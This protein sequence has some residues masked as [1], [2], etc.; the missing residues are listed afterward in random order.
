MDLTVKTS[1]LQ[2]MVSKV[3]KCVSNNKLIPITSLMS[4]KV[5]DNVLTLTTTDASAYFYVSSKERFLCDDFEISVIADTF[6][7]LVQ[8]ITTETITLTLDNNILEVN[9]NGKYKLELPLDDSKPIKFVK[10]LPDVEPEP[11]C[12]IKRSYIDKILNYNKP[13]LATAMNIPA[14]CSYYCGDSVRTT[15]GTRACET[16]IKLFDSPLL[17]TPQVMELLGIMS[18]EDINVFCNE[19]YTLYFTSTDTV[20]APVQPGIENF[21]SAGFDKLINTEFPSSC[22]VDKVSVEELLDRISLFVDSYDKKAITLTFTNEGIMFSSKKSSGVEL[23]PYIESEGFV[24]YTC[25]L[26]IEYFKAQI[27]AQ[28]DDTLHIFYGA[29]KFIKTTSENVVQ[30]LGLIKNVEGTD[31]EE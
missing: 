18:E 27:S 14:I 21:P 7:K 1:E 31:G 25:N 2:E 26:D 12:V 6:V 16:G 8:K 28:K 29:D 20:Y 23:V 3:S 9:G 10:K 11:N 4:I 5:K 13:T 19:E 17:V 15:D 30:I 24:A 22:R